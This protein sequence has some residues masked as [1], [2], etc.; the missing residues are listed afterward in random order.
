VVL[1]KLN[2][3]SS[4][5]KLKLAPLAKAYMNQREENEMEGLFYHMVVPQ[6]SRQE[7]SRIYNIVFSRFINDPN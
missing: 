1:G 6:M 4:C 3:A 7:K 5:I 2:A